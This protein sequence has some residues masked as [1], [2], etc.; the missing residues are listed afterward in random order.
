MAR[1][2]TFTSATANPLLILFFGVTAIL[3]DARFVPSNFDDI[4]VLIF[5]YVGTWL[6]PR[7]YS[8]VPD[9]DLLRSEGPPQ[10]AGDDNYDGDGDDDFDAEAG[11]GGQVTPFGVTLS[12]H[13][14]RVH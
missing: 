7:W 6:A 12:P 14:P 9:P 1:L 10:G 8:L 2:L 5:L 11:A 4:Y 13:R 3:V